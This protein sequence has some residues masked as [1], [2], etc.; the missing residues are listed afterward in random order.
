LSHAFSQKFF[1]Q[2]VALFT[3][4]KFHMGEILQINTLHIGN[5][6]PASG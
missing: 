5:V 2:H 3:H 4:Q 1:D 6:F